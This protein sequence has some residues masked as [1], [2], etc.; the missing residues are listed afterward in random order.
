MVTTTYMKDKSG[1]NLP[2]FRVITGRSMFLES[3]ESWACSTWE[4]W[5]S[6]LS[7]SPG[8]SRSSWESSTLRPSGP[9]YV[10]WSFYYCGVSSRSCRSSEQEWL[11][12][13]WQMQLDSTRKAWKGLG[14]YG[15]FP[16]CILVDMSPYIYIPCQNSPIDCSPPQWGLLKAWWMQSQQRRHYFLHE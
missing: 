3:L 15:S 10:F 9:I 14:L 5:P 16:R 12:G 11:V 6:L 2:N 7:F 8:N 1:W 13:G 4:S